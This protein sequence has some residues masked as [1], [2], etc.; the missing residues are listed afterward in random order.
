M[1]KSG[2]LPHI[3]KNAYAGISREMWILAITM[4]INRCGSMVL[5]FMSVY[6]T[7]EL[8]FTLPQIGVVLAM[9]GIGS[10]AGAF[11]GGKVVDKIGYYP[12]LIWSLVLS[13][14]MIITLGFMQHYYLVAF[15][16][17]MVTCTGDMFR[18]ANSAAIHAYSKPENYSQS[19]ALN[20]LAMN[21]G[22][23][24]GP[25]LGGFLAHKSYSFLFWTDGLTCILAAVFLRF[26]LP[27]KNDLN[28][29][30]EQQEKSKDK[31]PYYDKNYL[32][33]LLFTS[34]YAMCFFQLITAFPLYFKQEYHLSE[35]H[36]GLMMAL[37]GV[38]V[39]VIEMFLIYY[40]KDKW[41]QFNF[42]SLG[43]ILLIVAFLILIP[44]HSIYIL[45]I[46]VLV[47]TLSEM[48]AMPF[49]STYSLL[50]AK[51]KNMGDYMAL[52]AMSWSLAL[53]IAPL[54]GTQIINHF[55]FSMLWL[56]VSVLGF[57]SLIGI[58]KLGQ[59]QQV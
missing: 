26:L 9:F 7:V 40:I 21:L 5:L 14:L 51:D 4:L 35:Q 58:Y 37:N 43:I 23:T 34:I 28:K 30:H 52:Y 10:L 24:V 47:L 2:T 59:K 13:G 56:F 46:S 55:G 20:R 41:T 22:F 11:I 39:A 53:I 16:T 57:V 27:V 8:H 48:L 19:I 18:P 44:F 54:I 31:S 29:P 6:L 17:F 25:M 38:G 3:F 36:I 12:V 42:I 45:I 1:F 50:Q 49:M 32:Y 15:F 33:F